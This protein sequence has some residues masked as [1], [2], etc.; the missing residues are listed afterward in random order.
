MTFY[1]KHHSL[2]IPKGSDRTRRKALLAAWMLLCIQPAATAQETADSVEADGKM[3]GVI[4]QV[5]DRLNRP[6]RY[7][8]DRYVRKPPTKFILTLRG[9]VQQT[10]VRINDYTELDTDWGLANSTQTNLRMQER[11]HYKAGGYITY[12][13]IRAGLGMSVGRKSAEKSTSL[14]LG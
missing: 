13:G 6:P 10:G 14:Y 1:S 5:L 3:P 9:R 8:D 7:L 11:L 12:S 4:R 2:P